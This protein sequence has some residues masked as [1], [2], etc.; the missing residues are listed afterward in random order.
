MTAAAAMMFADT[1]LCRP[2]SLT[3]CFEGT[4][5]KPLYKY[6]RVAGVGEEVGSQT[7]HPIYKDVASLI[8]WRFPLQLCTGA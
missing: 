4:L 5:E 1:T 8:W 7:T 3:S 2:R 6:A